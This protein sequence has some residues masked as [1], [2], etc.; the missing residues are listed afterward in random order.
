MRSGAMATHRLTAN[1]MGALIADLLEDPNMVRFSATKI[2]EG[3]NDAIAE[4][5]SELAVCLMK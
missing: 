3:L 2:L 1:Q 4:C 5:V